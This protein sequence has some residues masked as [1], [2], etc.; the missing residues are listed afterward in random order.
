MQPENE[1]IRKARKV[2]GEEVDEIL[3]R[4]VTLVGCLFIG[5]TLVGDE[6]SNTFGKPPHEKSFISVPF[7]DFAIFEIE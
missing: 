2:K 6:G 3:I 1:K 7:I 5:V 4:I